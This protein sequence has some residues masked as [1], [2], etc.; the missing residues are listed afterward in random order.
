ML[1]VRLLQ[2]FF[3]VAKLGGFHK[4]AAQLNIT[5]PAVSQR[6][7]QLEHLLGTR[8][9]ARTRRSLF[10]TEKG[11][12]LLA[13]VEQILSLHD[14]MRHAIA[15]PQ[16]V[17]GTLRLGVSETIVHTWLPDFMRA[18]NERHPHLAVE[19]DAGASPSL[20][21]KLL[22][23]EIDLGFL[24]LPL[25][26]ADLEMTGLGRFP[27]AF[28]AS[29]SLELGGRRISLERLAQYPIITFARGTEAHFEVQR[30]YAELP[31]PR[32]HASSTLWPMVKMAVDGLA[33]AC[34]PPAVV[35]RELIEG[36][37]QIVKTSAALADLSFAACWRRTPE[38]HMAKAVA[39]LAAEIATA[40]SRKLVSG[41]SAKVGHRK[42]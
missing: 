10:C 3:W 15:A 41:K 14:A 20:E 39:K 2:A 21:D 7:A 26:H 23:H 36:E 38:R 32:L 42:P 37:L 30:I 18:L 6:V 24:V 40:A 22:A 12:G 31:A 35:D 27:M 34:I 13:Y 4:A 8:L 17:H 19:I 33:V 9:I 25:T 1:D 28:V 11:L 5:Q 16:A 29:P